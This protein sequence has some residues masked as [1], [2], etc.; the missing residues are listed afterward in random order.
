M[1]VQLPLPGSWRGNVSRRDPAAALEEIQRDKSATTY[2]I[3][4]ELDRLADKHGV[5]HTV[6]AKAAGRYVDDLLGDVFIELEEALV[7]ERDAV[8]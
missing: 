3:E 7:R 5:S 6:I 8:G 1:T 4:L 2:A